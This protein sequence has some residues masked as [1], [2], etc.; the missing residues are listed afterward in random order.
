MSDVAAPRKYSDEEREAMYHLYVQGRQP[1]DIA[2]TCAVGKAG[3]PAFEVPPRSV[4]DI[5]TGIARQ[6]GQ[7]TPAEPTELDEEARLRALF[8]RGIEQQEALA[9][10]G[11]ADPKALTELARGLRIL[12]GSPRRNGSHR[13]AKPA[14]PKR[15]SNLAEELRAA[16]ARRDSA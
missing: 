4:H 6:R 3:V 12:N 2:R 10:Q 11:E 16:L 1:T 14:T 13:N 5:V 7:Q 8:R 9:T 15:T